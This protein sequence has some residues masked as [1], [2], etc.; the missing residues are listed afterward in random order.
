M[1]NVGKD[2]VTRC[3]AIDEKQRATAEELLQH[4]FIA[5]EVAMETGNDRVG[6]EEA[7]ASSFPLR[8]GKRNHGGQ[9]E[10]KLGKDGREPSF[11]P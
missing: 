6:G 3:L 5:Q 4:P 9:S 7:T 11:L 10:G 1:S 2:F 8:P